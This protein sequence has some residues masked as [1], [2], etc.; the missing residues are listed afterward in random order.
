[1]WTSPAQKAGL[2]EGDEILSVTGQGKTGKNYNQILN[3]ISESK[4]IPLDFTVR[5]P[6]IVPAREK[7]W[8][9][10]RIARTAGSCI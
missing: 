10:T 5:R 4:G 6:D 1:M 3:I 7:L 8:E 2:K 9:S